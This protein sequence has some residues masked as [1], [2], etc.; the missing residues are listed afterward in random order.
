MSV[1]SGTATI[2]DV[3]TGLMVYT[4]MAAYTGLTQSIGVSHEFDKNIVKDKSGNDIT[5]I[6]ANENKKLSISL[7][8]SGSS[9]ANAKAQLILPPVNARV[10]LSTFDAA[11]GLNGDWIYLGGASWEVDNQL[12]PVRLTLPI[13]KRA[14]NDLSTPVT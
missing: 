6:S 3:L 7:I 14:A 1:Q 2:I 4:G 11:L 9:L 5:V 8:P 10:T 13:E 12:N